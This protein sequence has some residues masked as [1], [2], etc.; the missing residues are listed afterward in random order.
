MNKSEFENIFDELVVTKLK[1]YGFL[2]NK[3]HLYLVDNDVVFSFIRL[4]GKLNSPHSVAHILCIK[5]NFLPNLNEK[6]IKGFDNEVFA[7]PFKFKP[8]EMQKIINKPIKYHSDNLNYD[9]E[10]FNFDTSSDVEVHDYLRNIGHY[11]VETVEWFSKFTLVE[12]KETIEKN[13]QSDWIENIWL[14]AYAKE[15]S[16]KA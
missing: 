14:S 8:N 5:H 3:K 9:Y 1:E 2:E 4:G 11:I 16:H 7:Y 15:L 13:S 12:I 6:V 10:R